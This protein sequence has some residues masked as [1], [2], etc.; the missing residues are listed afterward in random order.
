MEGQVVMQGDT[1]TLPF[2]F[3]QPQN[4]FSA[5]YQVPYQIHLLC[6]SSPP[7]IHFE[8]VAALNLLPRRLNVLQEHLLTSL[9][10]TY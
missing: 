4:P 8:N 5:Q 6:H 10:Q 7:V 9:K 2:S 1:H 3:S